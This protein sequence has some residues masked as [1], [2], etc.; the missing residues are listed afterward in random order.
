MAENNGSSELEILIAMRKV[1]AE[2]IKDTTPAH[3]SMIHPLSENTVQG[4]RACLGMISGR[5]RELA[6]Q[7]GATEQR[8]YY[9]GEKPEAETV[10]LENI[11][12]EK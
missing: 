12:R 5:E 6:E 9:L 1:L 2:I 10:S 11:K 8:P 4:I 7:A 3:R